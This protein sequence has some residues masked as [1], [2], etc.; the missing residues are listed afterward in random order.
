MDKEITL[1]EALTGVDFTLTH[2]DGRKIRIR[3]NPGDVITPE[4]QKTVENQGMPFHKKVYNN[5]NLII[6]FKIKFP[7]SIDSKQAGI[8][9]EALTEKGAAK[10]AKKGGDKP[11]GEIAETCEMKNFEEYHRNL[12]AG[13]GE[14]GNDSEE[15][16]DDEGHHGHGGQKMGCQAQ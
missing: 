16:E 10:G 2:L 8:I 1:I 3:N 12:H 13:G 5:G 7:A 15:D 4:M 9:T 11:N 6:T 14:R